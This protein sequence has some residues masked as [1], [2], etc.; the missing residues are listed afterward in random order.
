MPLSFAT[1]VS[2][3]NLSKVVK[4]TMAESMREQKAADRDR[5]CVAIHGFKEHGRDIGDVNEL[6]QYID[7]QVNVISVVRIGRPPTS[8]RRPPL[9]KVLLQ[10]VADKNLFLQAAKFLKDDPSTSSIFI[11]PRLSPVEL[12]KL[13]KTQDR[14]CQLNAKSPAMADDRKPFLVISGR[15]MQRSVSG[16]LRA[17][18]DDDENVHDTTIKRSFPPSLASSAGASYAAAGLLSS[19]SP[20]TSQPATPPKSSTQ[21]APHQASQLSKNE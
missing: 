2:A 8:T 14:C 1:V 12:A 4:S 16:A 17:F 18:H 5:A 19:L 9:L 10:S 13:R 15:L 11:A 7:C 21:P 20:P 6:C 3:G